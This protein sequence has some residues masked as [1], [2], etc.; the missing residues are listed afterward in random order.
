[1]Q[2][3]V[4]DSRCAVLL[5]W[6][7]PALPM[8]SPCGLKSADGLSIVLG[9]HMVTTECTWTVPTSAFVTVIPEIMTSVELTTIMTTTTN[10]TTS[11]TTTLLRR[12]RHALRMRTLR[13]LRSASGLSIV[14]G[15]HMAVTE[16]TWTV[17]TI[18]FILTITNTITSLELMAATISTTMHDFSFSSSSHDVDDKDCM[19][20]RGRCLNL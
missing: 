4:A 1:M 19:W 18:V 10:R 20:R 14:L 6:S 11:M 2:H 8:R 7:R 16:C 15:G 5:R 9:G 3:S 12:S 13:E 17:L